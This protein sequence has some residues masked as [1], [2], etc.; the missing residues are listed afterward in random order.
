VVLGTS[1]KIGI[2]DRSRRGL[3]VVIVG[4][5]AVELTASVG[6][7]EYDCEATSLEVIVSSASSDTHFPDG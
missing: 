3:F 4:E 7:G 5:V 1:G 2:P 6:D